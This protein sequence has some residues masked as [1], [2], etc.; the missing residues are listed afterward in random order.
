VREAVTGT[1]G[2]YPEIE[3]ALLTPSDTQFRQAEGGAGAAL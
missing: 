3:S 1:A 2:A